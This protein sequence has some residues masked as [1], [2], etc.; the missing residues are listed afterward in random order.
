[1]TGKG[2]RFPG[3]P[4]PPLAASVAVQGGGGARP[5]WKPEP[6]LTAEGAV[7]EEVYPRS[8][9]PGSESGQESDAVDSA[10]HSAPS[11]NNQ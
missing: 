7:R 8:G 5:G 10:R 6:R 9:T 11:T 1:M 2:L 4:Q 3:L